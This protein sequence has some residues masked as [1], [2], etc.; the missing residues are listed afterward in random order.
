MTTYFKA[1]RL[2]GTAFQTSKVLYTVGGRVR[3]LPF[4]GE[5]KLCGQGVLHAADVPAE[6]LVGGWWPCR[7]FEVAGKPIA[8][9]GHKFGFKQLRV[10]RELDAHLALGPNGREVAALI[11]RAR[12]LTWD[13]ARRLHAAW[14]TPRD[15]AWAATWDAA[16]DAARAAAWAAA[17]DAA[18]DAAR[19]AARVA[20]RAAS[21]AALA[22]VVRD[23]I[24]GEHF[25]ALYGRWQQVIG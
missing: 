19:A 11:E 20:G 5:R 14:D 10:V 2:D 25:N 23:L 8:Q 7:L 21:R 18:G 17:E 12:S 22:L 1:T 16:E 13:E 3:P 9:G 6:A 4:D 24:S 15:A